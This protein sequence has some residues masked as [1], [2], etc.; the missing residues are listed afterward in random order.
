[1]KIIVPGTDNK[2]FVPDNNC[3]SL[4]C[5]LS[6]FTGSANNLRIIL[7]TISRCRHS[8]GCQWHHWSG[9]KSLQGWCP[10]ARC[11]ASVY[12]SSCCPRRCR[13][14]FPEQFL[15]PRSCKRTAFCSGC[16][17]PGHIHKR[18]IDRRFM[19]NV[20]YSPSDDIYIEGEINAK[21]LLI[22]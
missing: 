16:C 20:T 10:P 8:S 17:R 2:C 14:R 7:D 15:P 19:P 9:R 22:L 3:S 13:L 12:P 18:A 6:L 5:R 11:T 4:S 21:Y 1:M